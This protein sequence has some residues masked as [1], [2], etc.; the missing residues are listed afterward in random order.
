MK[1]SLLIFSMLFIAFNTL[2]QSRV[3]SGSIADTVGAPL[4]DVYVKLKSA[5]DSVTAVTNATGK[6]RF[7]AVTST[8]FLITTTTIG[9]ESFSQQYAIGSSTG[10]AFI[11]DPIKLKVQI[12]QLNEVVVVS[13]TPVIIKEDTV[14]YKASAYKV[15]EGA[16]VEDVIKKL[17][18]VTVDKDGNVT[19]QG[20]EVKRLRVNGKDYFG[21]DII[22]ATQN[23][24]A[25]IIDNIQIID[26]YGDRANV[27]GIK[28][29]ESEKIL[30]IN[31]Q[32]GKNKGNFGNGNL[33]AGTEERYAARISANNFKEDRQL[34][35]VASLNNTNANSFNFN[36]GGR[37]GGARGANFGGGDRGGGGDGTTY[38]QSIGL[39][40]RDT[41]GKKITSFGSYSFSGRTNNTFGTSFQQDFN[42]LNNVTTNRINNSRTKSENHRL[43]WNL[44]YKMDTANYLKITPYFSY[45]KSSAQSD[46]IS[47]INKAKYFT[48][49]K[50]NSQGN[51]TSPSYGT[52]VLFN[53]KFSKKGRN[54]SLSGTYD[55]ST[56]E[57]DRISQNN[58]F[59]VDS[60]GA[61]PF[62]NELNQYQF[63]GNNNVNS[64]TNIRASYAEPISRYTAVEVSYNWNNSITKSTRSVDDFDAL[65]GTKTRNNKQSND[66]DYH[67]ITNRYGLNLHTFKTKYNY[68]V[69]VIAQPSNLVGND[70]G[71]KIT[72]TV[73]NF[74]IAP[75][76]RFVY[77][78]AR[79]HSLTATYGGSSRAPGFA[80]LQPV[81]DSSNIKNIVTGNPNLKAEFTNRFSLQYNKVGILKGT[82]LFTN[83]SFDQTQNKIVSS[84]VNDPLGTGRTTSYLNT[85]GFY[86]FNANA[87][88]S[89][90]FFNK[91]FTASVNANGSYDNNISFT[92]NQKNTGYNWTLRPGARLRL[93]L[94]D[95]IE[96]D[97]NST[98]SINKTVTRYT[99]FT[100]KT[101]VRSLNIGLNGK[102][103]FLKNWTLGYDLNK[104]YNT[105]YLSS[106]NINPTLLNMY[107][108][109][110][111]LKGNAGLLRLQGFDLF[112][113]NT[114]ISREVNGTT[115]TDY[116]NNRLGKYFMLSFNLR[117]QKFAGKGFNRQDGERGGQ[118]DRRNGN[119]GGNGPRRD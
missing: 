87:S 10:T 111:F 75:N 61:L 117:L 47:Q 94:Q 118:G 101:E 38:M 62:S 95:I 12:N 51:S 115:V 57:Q 16:P 54:F 96:V 32:K 4:A 42:P 65:T 56:R 59:N 21:G 81:S 40:Y 43:T 34:S 13:V 100:N 107:V 99:T 27:T 90:P 50:S 114:G 17:P 6:F 82:S 76:A 67:F 3:V 19:A 91:K 69:G 78:F 88:Y 14:E 25:D 112:N 52:D 9:Y 36:A 33:A 109:R 18:G 35:L 24:P 11:I 66:Y 22:T 86:G 73:K 72:T 104:T 84:R 98:Y 63:I 7:P 93:D 83:I 29:G 113:Q 71:R 105:G 80:Q 5:T 23:L 102:N 30:N 103:Y 44:E 89:K 26:D 108:E 106:K 41:W 39:N 85:N 74:N 20:K 64:T 49:N 53:H 92:D 119:F 8:S 68:S 58:Y 28:E 1:R 31:I 70:L 37:G 2:A 77:N 60:T 110:R 97:L 15:R 45:A 55:H 48:S 116:Q 46:G 79:S